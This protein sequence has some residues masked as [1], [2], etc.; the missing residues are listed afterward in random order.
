MCEAQNAL[1]KMKYLSDVQVCL[2]QEWRQLDQHGA[3]G[4]AVQ[5]ASIV[6]QLKQEICNVSKKCPRQL[7]K[8]YRVAC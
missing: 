4:A 7:N 3:E 2:V 8:N 6:A 1:H 5:V